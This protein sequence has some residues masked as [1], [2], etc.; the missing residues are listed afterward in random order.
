MKR[1]RHRGPSKHGC[2]FLP[3]GGQL[4]PPSC[5][6]CRR[7]NP[8]EAPASHQYAT[9]ASHRRRAAAQR[10]TTRRSSTRS[11][12]ERG[13]G[14]TRTAQRSQDRRLSSNSRV[15]QVMPASARARQPL[16]Q[17][18]TKVAVLQEDF[19]SPLTDS[20]RRPPPYPWRFSDVTR[21]H[22]RSLAT[23]FLLQISPFF[24]RGKRRWTSPVSFLMCPFC[25]RAVL[26]RRTTEWT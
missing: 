6:A 1:C 5:P 9:T 16:T 7:E 23:R 11:I 18:A 26:F 15:H 10:R 21:G 25:V 12:S 19:R 22:V 2:S 13:S 17:S 8:T 14:E 20:N 4:R 3:A 24:V